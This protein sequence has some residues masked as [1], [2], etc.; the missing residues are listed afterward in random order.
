MYDTD[1]DDW[2]FANFE[3]HP[4]AQRFMEFQQVYESESLRGRILVTMGYVEDLL[5]RAIAA[6]L[7]DTNP[8]LLKDFGKRSL[9]S[10][11]AKRTLAYLLGLIDDREYA[12]IKQMA[13]IRNAY[14]HQPMVKESDSLIRQHTRR[15]AVLLQ[16]DQYKES[17]SD[18][19][20]EETWGMTL[21]G[22]LTS[23]NNR[24]ERAEE[25]RIR[26]KPWDLS[27]P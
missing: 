26:Y 20:V 15:L 4:A 23:L 6:S 16:I 12:I 5:A 7:I 19:Y 18:R 13:D 10:L 9:A 1:D 11:S 17:E 27:A 14:A 2:D 24:P 21:W 3:L 8:S 22:L 25:R